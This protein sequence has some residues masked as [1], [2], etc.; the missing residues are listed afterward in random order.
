MEH[1]QPI[2]AIAIFAVAFGLIASE[3]VHRV[4]VVLGAAGLMTVLGLIP[5]SDVFYSPHAGIDWDVV[6]LLL[7]MMI[8]VGVLKQTGV[9]EFLGVWAAKAS[10]GRPYRLLVLLMLITAVASPFVD[11]VTTVMLVAPVTIAVCRMLGF[12]PAPYLI[13]EVLA[14]NIGGAATL[15]GDPPNIIIGSRANLSYNDFLVHMLPITVIVFVA[16]VLLARVLFRS[17]FAS[18]PGIALPPDL[19]AR[20]KITD[21]GLLWRS[22][23]ILALVTIAFTLH[24]VIHVEPA[25][26]ALLGAGAMVLVAKQPMS[27]VLR[28]V[29]WT[30]LVFF[31]GLFVMVGGLVDTGVIETVGAWAADWIDGDM[32]LASTVLIFGSALLGAFFDNI[33][34][35]TAM[36]PVVEDIVAAAS[37]DPGVQAVWWAF[38]L[39]AD[40]GGNGTAIAAS[41]N[42]V[43]L[44][45]AAREGERISFWRF[46]KYGIVT[47]LMSVGLAWV[48]VWFRY[49]SGIVA[50]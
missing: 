39:G 22:L 13:A 28:E 26:V 23:V 49:F 45:I 30:T 3:K 43:V 11:N 48:Y 35:V 42:I 18:G 21:M 1:W 12:Q 10:R 44:A 29:E 31:M 15:V 14:A 6:F 50:F 16:F 40:F 37:G 8:I 9:F 7:G 25:I 2:A 20:S 33:P 32:L 24:A 36:S 34:Y 38:A 27:N 41:A 47:T 46:T 19:D 17:A 5:G 4:A